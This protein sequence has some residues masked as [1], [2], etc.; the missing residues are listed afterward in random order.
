MEAP[1][2]GFLEESGRVSGV[3]L[4]DGR[5]LRAA[6]TIAADG[7]SSLVRALGLIEVETLGA[8]MD[9]FWFRLPKAGTGGDALRGSVQTGRT[10]LV[11]SRPASAPPRS[12]SSAGCLV[13]GITSAPL[14]VRL[15]DRLPLLRRIPGR[16]IGLGFRRER[17]RSPS[18]PSPIPG[19]S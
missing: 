19:S 1:V 16:L 11:G 10:T 2:R 13:I 15:L 17:V 4:S 12:E 8:P 18:S 6:L 5:E 3:T 14:F 7:R 9:V